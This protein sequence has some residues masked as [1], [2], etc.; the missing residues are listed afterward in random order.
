MNRLANLLCLYQGCL[1]RRP[2]FTK[3]V[4]GGATAFAGDVICQAVV[5]KSK[6]GF[7]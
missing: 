7:E 6:A 5:E 2:L 1:E 4:T 3:M